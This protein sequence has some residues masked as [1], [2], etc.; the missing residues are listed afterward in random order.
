M[1]SAELQA[2]NTKVRELADEKG[3]KLVQNVAAGVIGLIVWPVLFA[4][5]V[6]G[7][8]SHN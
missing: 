6:K 4:L 8:S 7:N 2:N 1:I 5:D 3:V